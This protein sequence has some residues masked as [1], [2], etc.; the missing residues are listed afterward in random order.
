MNIS[1][2]D[3]TANSTQ[4][5][6]FIYFILYL[7]SGVVFSLGLSIAGMIDPQKIINFLNVFSSSWDPALAFVLGSAAPVYLVAFLFLRKRG[8][9]L[10][11]QQFKHPTPRPIDRKLVVG[12]IIFGSGWGLAGICPGPAITHIAFLE[13]PFALFLVAMVVG[14]EI[15]K[16]WSA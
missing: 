8:R 2:S 12:S 16:R 7:L 3:S 13:L 15:E 5:S 1:K 14:F 10:N 4:R 9:S 11:G 6:K